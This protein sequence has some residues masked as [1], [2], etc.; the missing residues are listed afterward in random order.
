VIGFFD[1]QK[2][3]VDGF[4]ERDLRIVEALASQISIAVEN[5]R[6]YE[7]IKNSKAQLAFINDLMSHDMSNINQIALGY[8]DVL[9]E[10]E[11][12]EKQKKYILTTKRAIRRSAR[13]VTNAKILKR[14]LEEEE[15]KR[16]TELSSQ[17]EEAIKN[18]SDY[19]GKKVSI[20]YAPKRGQIVSADEF[21]PKVFENLLDNAI[22]FTPS[23]NVRVAVDVFEEE[24]AYRIEI[25][26]WGK[27]V[28]REMKKDIFLR[29]ERLQEGK[30]GSGLGLYASKRIV[31]GNSGKIWVE[32]NPE[33][34]A[35]FCVEIPRVR[36]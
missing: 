25:K 9:S 34:G 24:N 3:I 13:L 36:R 7:E 31:E 20:E 1:V 28:S 32:D 35:I 27:G 2:E 30:L 19:P 26:D 4:E 5:A 6:L 17:I 14:M 18:V 10:T 23:E 33:G 15:E 21:L 29:Y 16:E 8:I 12:S 11:L 22:K